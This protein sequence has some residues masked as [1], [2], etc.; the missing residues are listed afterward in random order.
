[1]NNHD[2]WRKREAEL[3]QEA[4]KIYKESKDFDSSI[5][6]DSAGSEVYDL[7]NEDDWKKFRI[8]ESKVKKKYKKLFNK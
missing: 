3:L 8:V 5:D 6:L 4:K 1:M 7:M 2:I